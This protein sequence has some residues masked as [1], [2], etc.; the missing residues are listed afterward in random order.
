LHQWLFE[1]PKLDARLKDSERERYRSAN[2]YAGRYCARL[3]PALARGL[4]DDE[5]RRELRH[6]YR[7]PQGAKLAHI[8]AP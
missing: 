5:L 1:L 2:R 3:A 4:D 6:F 7:L 8:D